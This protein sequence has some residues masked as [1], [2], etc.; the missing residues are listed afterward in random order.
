M[1]IFLNDSFLSAVEDR[2]DPSKLMVRGRIKGD[3][4]RV[5]PNACVTETPAADYRYRARIDRDTVAEAMA[6]AVYQLQ[7]DNFKNSVEDHQRHSAYFGCWQSMVNYQTNA[8]LAQD[9]DLTEPDE[10]DLE[11]AF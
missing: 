3:I 8:H 5:F 7:Y 6:R 2:V 1:W 4:E 9:Y 11:F 10:D